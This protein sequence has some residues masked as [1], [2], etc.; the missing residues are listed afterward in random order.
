M[1]NVLF[2]KGLVIGIIV[3]FIGMSV[4]SSTGS[5]RKNH[6]FEIEKNNETPYEEISPVD[7]DTEFWALLIGVG[8]YAGKPEEWRPYMIDEVADFREKF[9]ISEHWEDKNINCSFSSN[10]IH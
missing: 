9:L 8:I 6:A 10:F 1:R 5:N 3:L 4:S 7:N 2:K